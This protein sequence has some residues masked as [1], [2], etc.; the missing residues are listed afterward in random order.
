MRFPH[1]CIFKSLPFHFTENAMK[2]LHPH[3]CFHIVL[4][5]HTETMKTT[6]SVEGVI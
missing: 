1:K 5:V 2:V 3:D 4:P 6:E